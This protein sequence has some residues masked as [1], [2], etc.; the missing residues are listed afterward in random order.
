MSAWET[1]VFLGSWICEQV[2]LRAPVR[3]NFPQ[4]EGLLVLNLNLA[5]NLIGEFLKIRDGHEV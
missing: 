2:Q 1:P 3:D 5:T 4:P